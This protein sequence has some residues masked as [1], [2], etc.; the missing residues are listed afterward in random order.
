MSEKTGVKEVVHKNNKRI[1]ELQEALEKSTGHLKYYQ[2]LGCN[3]SIEN[4]I[5]SLCKQIER[6]EELLEK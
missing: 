5:S 3:C 4:G 2:K 6:N 1:K